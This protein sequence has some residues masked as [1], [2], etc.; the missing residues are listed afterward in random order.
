MNFAMPACSPR[1]GCFQLARGVPVGIAKFMPLRAWRICKAVWHSGIVSSR[2]F[3]DWQRLKSIYR[4]RP[5]GVPKNLCLSFR[6]AGR[7]SSQCLRTTASMLRSSCFRTVM[8]VM[9]FTFVPTAPST[10]P[11]WVVSIDF[12]SSW[13]IK[14]AW[15]YVDKSASARLW[16]SPGDR[17][18]GSAISAAAAQPV[19]MSTHSLSLGIL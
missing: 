6:L 1:D 17:T 16:F 8:N 10:S 3:S 19:C 9:F 13:K 18:H 5:A 2:D 15:I 11:G 7:F 12:S 14:L 4:E